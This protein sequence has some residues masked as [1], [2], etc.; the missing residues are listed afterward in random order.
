MKRFFLIV[1]LLLQNYVHAAEPLKAGVQYEMPKHQKL[2]LRITQVSKRL[3]WL[4]RDDNGKLIS[5]DLGSIIVAQN[6]EDIK[7]LDQ[8][9]SEKT[10]PKGTKF[11]AKV[12]GTKPAK[13]F[14]RKGSAELRFFAIDP[15][16]SEELYAPR[17]SM[18]EYNGKDLVQPSLSSNTIELDSELNYTSQP[19]NFKDSLE[20]ISAVGAYAVAGAIAAPLMIFSSSSLLAKIASFSAISNPYLLGGVS[21][22]GASAGLAY[23]IMK[24][25]KSINLE[26]GSELE[27]KLEDPWL[28]VQALEEAE[29]DGTNATRKKEQN[30]IFDLTINQVKKTKD[31]F[32]D[33][34]LRVSISYLNK[35]DL[36]LRY[37]SFQLVDSMG[38]EYEPNYSSVSQE[39]FGEL[40]KQ[41]NFDLFFNV[42]FPKTRHQLRVLRMH[43]QKAIAVADVVL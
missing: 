40:P 18:G 24:Q 4:E 5:P 10:L 25:G 16:G 19:T 29:L 17:Y 30:A 23:G 20:N 36:E 42:E 43:D 15:H 13:S 31:D 37:S 22:I 34:C 9:G 39:V 27:I 32:G 2:D 11:Y 1:S 28:I 3:P 33:P 21:A 38:K 41:G 8:Y 6:I 7:V 35:S 12:I 14:W 26:P